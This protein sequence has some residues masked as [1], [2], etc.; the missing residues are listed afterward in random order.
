MFDR[1]WG[2]AILAPARILPHS[3]H[4]IATFQEAMLDA[5]KVIKLKEFDTPTVANGVAL[6]QVRDNSYGYTGPD[7]HALMPEMGVQVGVAVTARMDTTSPG[8]EDNTPLWKEFLQAMADVCQRDNPLPVFAVI[9]SV[10]LRPRYTVTIG[11]GMATHLR[12]AG[13]AG[14]LTNGSIRDLQGVR[15]VGLPCWAAGV[16]PMHGQ[17]RWLDVNSPVI[18][19]GM[20]VQPGD[21]IHADENGALAIPAQVADRVHAQAV[22]VSEREAKLF[23][24]WRAPGMTIQKRLSQM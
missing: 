13:A 24:G 1:E 19:D 2:P 5:D 17:I 21:V 10:G 14:F 20:T 3:G 6:L 15:E 16:S 7:M 9:E 8:E 23:A 11:D 22:A 4:R 12:L 18:I